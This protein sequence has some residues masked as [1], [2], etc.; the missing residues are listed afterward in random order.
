MHRF[1][2]A[3]ACAALLAAPALADV[4]A[5]VEAWQRGDFK[6]AIAEWQGPAE[7]GD[8]DAQF[9][10]GQAYKLGRGVPADLHQAEEWYRRAALQNHPQAQDNYGLALF[11]NGKH[12]EAVRWLT[13]SAGRGEPRAQFVL[14]TM[15]FNGDSVGKDYARAYALLTRA[16]ASGLPKA[17]EVLAQVDRFISPADKLQG[18]E[19]ARQYEADAARGGPVAVAAVPPPRAGG[20]ISSADLPPSSAY[21]PDPAPPPPEPVPSPTPA[22]AP[23]PKPV[24]VAAAPPPLPAPSPTPRSVTP[25]PASPPPA[26][27]VDGGWR[28][29]LGAFGEPGNA[30]KLWRQVADRF[31]NRSVDYI[32]SGRLTLVLVGPYASEA[33][34]KAGC[35]RVSPCIPTRR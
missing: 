2:L 30:Q 15:F 7:R 22:P 1:A 21:Q 23:A 13:L 28:L 26:R 17:R 4:K 10:L 3:A 33:E 24:R 31:P 19:L 16:A 34:A 6:R 9:N 5:G 25:P 27:V 32:R 14:G 8:P 29:Q 20:S 18:L 12:A 11:Q 35:A